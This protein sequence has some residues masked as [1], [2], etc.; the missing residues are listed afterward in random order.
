MK[1]GSEPPS[2]AHLTIKQPLQ[3]GSGKEIYFGVFI[4]AGGFKQ[5]P[6]GQGVPDEHV[7][8]AQFA[9]VWVDERASVK[10]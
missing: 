10:P 9:Q 1:L 8:Q 2:Q 6:D 3:F 7:K 4:V 5:A